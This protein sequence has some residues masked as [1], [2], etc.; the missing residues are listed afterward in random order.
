MKI[1]MKMSIVNVLFVSV[2]LFAVRSNL[3]GRS[4]VTVPDWI[5]SVEENVYVG[6]S[7]P[8]DDVVSA[9]EQAI[10]RALLL[11]SVATGQIMEFEENMEELYGIDYKKINGKIVKVVSFPAHDV[12]FTVLNEQRLA[13]GETIVL[14]H[15]LQDASDG[16]E[17]GEFL[18]NYYLDMT[19]SGDGIRNP[20]VEIRLYWAC[21]CG[22]KTFYEKI[23]RT[24]DQRGIIIMKSAMNGRDILH[25][26]TFS[27]SDSGN[28][29]PAGTFPPGIVYLDKYYI[30]ISKY[31]SI[32]RVWTSELLGLSLQSAKQ[33]SVYSY[34]TNVSGSEV[35]GHTA[36]MRD[37]TVASCKPESLRP[38]G[39]ENG[40]LHIKRTN[41]L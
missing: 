12:R 34:N 27:Y 23:Q 16:A 38:V 18:F 29:F 11:W 21:R 40:E 25:E 3:Y 1:R 4:E 30:S 39:I 22:G 41:S 19:T 37:S 26:K 9:R 15:V 32:G 6:I 2:M 17:E 33:E 10:G 28:P 7:E 36:V 31:G 24:T 35:T 14:L 5:F 20:K 13:S 8:D